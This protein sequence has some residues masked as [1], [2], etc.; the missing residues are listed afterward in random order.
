MESQR[1]SLERMGSCQCDGGRMRLA[2]KVVGVGLL[3][4]VTL[5]F[6][7]A[8]AAPEDHAGRAARAEGLV[9]ARCGVCHSTDLITQQ[10][11]DRSRWQATVGKMVHWGAELSEEEA[12]LLVEF[13]AARFHPNAPAWVPFSD[14]GEAEPLQAE[15]PSTQERPI[16]I[17]QQ[18]ATVFANNCQGCHGAGASGGFGPKLAGNPIL[19]AEP[20]FGRPSCTDAARCLPGSTH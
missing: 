20:C 15:H 17:A 1:V 6:S 5:W 2:R 7:R 13:L 9:L 8:G 18:G 4:L 14:I 10:R 3:R 11:L 19:N 16:G 12:G